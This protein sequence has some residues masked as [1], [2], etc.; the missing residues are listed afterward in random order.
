[1]EGLFEELALLAGGIANGTG[2]VDERNPGKSI[3]KHLNHSFAK[4]KLGTVTSKLI[5]FRGPR[6][7]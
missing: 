5:R 2:D 1:M 4:L 6:Q 7:S 3:M